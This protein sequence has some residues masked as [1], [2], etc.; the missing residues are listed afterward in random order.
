MSHPYSFTLGHGTCHLMILVIQ[1]IDCLLCHNY[2]N[3]SCGC[4]SVHVQTK[5]PRVRDFGPEGLP[6]TNGHSSTRLSSDV[7]IAE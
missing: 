3:P 6:C 2:Y 5:R 1:K 4:I 7:M